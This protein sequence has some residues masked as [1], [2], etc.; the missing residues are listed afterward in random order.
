[1]AFA[2]FTGSLAGKLFEGAGEVRHVGV[3]GLL[4]DILDIPAGR[5]EE[6]F[7]LF[8]A[9]AAQEIKETFARFPVQKLG[10][11]PL[12]DIDVVGDVAEGAMTAEECWQKV[13]ELN[14]FGE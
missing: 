11:M 1:M 10:E 3:A 12:A 6:S 14:P 8:D 13:M 5:P 2:V 9:H 7:R 4:G